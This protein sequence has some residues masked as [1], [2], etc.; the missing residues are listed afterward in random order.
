MI[1]KE[2]KLIRLFSDNNGV[3]RFK[4]ILKAEYHPDIIKRLE[5]DGLINK[6]A[7]GYYRLASYKKSPYPD[8]VDASL[9]VPRGVICLISAL[10]YHEATNEIPGQV[11]MAIPAGSR[12]G[13][14]EYPPVNYYRFS[15]EAWKAGVEEHDIEGQTIKVYSLAKTVADCYK[16]RNKIGEN[17]ARAALKTAVLEK[18]IKPDEILK[19]AAV[20]HVT[21]RVKQ[22]LEAIM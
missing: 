3:M 12:A 4:D 22:V 2:E 13:K 17:V 21:D 8:I 16:F 18:A 5:K 10:S 7:R 14:I 11:D 20:C 19:Y 15:P 1:T 9:Q 6:F